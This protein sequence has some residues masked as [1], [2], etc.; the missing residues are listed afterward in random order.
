MLSVVKVRGMGEWGWP[1]G[2]FLSFLSFFAANGPLDGHMRR[3]T[4]RVSREK[5]QDA[6][7]PKTMMAVRGGIRAGGRGASQRGR[8]R[9]NGDAASFDGSGREKAEGEGENEADRPGSTNE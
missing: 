5:A 9:R 2:E 4:E 7:K 6:H 8:G 1:A 3:L